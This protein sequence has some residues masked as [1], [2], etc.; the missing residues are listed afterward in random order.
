MRSRDLKTAALCLLL[1]LAPAPAS[2]RQALDLGVPRPVA[3]GIALYHLTDRGL[4]NP[5]SPISIW[6]VKIDLAL[7]DIRAA[8][9]TDEIVDTETVPETAVRHKAIAAVNGGF[10]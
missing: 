9:A 1:W 6:L 10:F 8:L 5:A 2:T 7:A 4:L 3:A